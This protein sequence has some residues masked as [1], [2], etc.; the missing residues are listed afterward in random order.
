MFK[1]AKRGSKKLKLSINGPSGSGKTYSMLSIAEHLVSDSD[2]PLDE[3]IAVIDTEH[4]A[5]LLYAEEY[6]NFA[7]CNLKQH[8]PTKYIDAIKEAAGNGFEVIIIDSLSH[9]WYEALSLVDKSGGGNFN[10]WA[11]VQPLLRDLIETILSCPCHV[12][13]SM[14]SA[15]DY[16]DGVGKN[17]KPTKVKVGTKA[18][19]K[20]GIEFEFDIAGEIDGNHELTISKS[21][22]KPLQDTTWSNPGK[23]LAEQLKQWLEQGAESIEVRPEQVVVKTE[24]AVKAAKPLTPRD[25]IAITFKN[26]YTNLG[27]SRDVA[28]SF[29]N[30]L[31]ANA[32]H[33]ADLKPDELKQCLDLISEEAKK[34][35]ALADKIAQPNNL[36]EPEGDALLAEHLPTDDG[37]AAVNW[38]HK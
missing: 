1:K 13:V 11:K 27:V 28:V 18:V 15:S 14:R 3:K 16:V 5:A 26:H 32:K 10:G 2:K 37:E 23:E 34:M 24:P 22:C 12:L 7:H 30:S 25:Q 19:F 38:M 20:D 8:H 6:F 36:V 33:P 29:M 21:R 4:E 17:G 31:D 9:A 35:Q